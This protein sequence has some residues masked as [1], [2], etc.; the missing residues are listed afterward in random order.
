MRQTEPVGSST[1]IVNGSGG[2]GHLTTLVISPPGA[3]TVTGTTTGGISAAL[4]TLISTRINASLGAGTLKP[5]SGGGPLTANVLPVQG[6]MKV[7]ILFPGCGLFLPIPLTLGGTRGMG[8]GGPTFTVNTFSPGPLPR[9]T[10]LGAPWTIGVASI[11]TDFGTVVRRG[12]AH[13]PA[14]ATSST[15]RP[16]GVVQLVTP[17]VATT[18]LAPPGTRLP[19]FGVLRIHFVPEPGTALLLGGGLA[20]LGITGRKR[21]HG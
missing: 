15:A 16:S 10:L 18:S 14:S 3:I 2:G 19:I 17:V 7:C 12:F 9:F 6:S 11:S 21:R 20:L 13:G 5:I 1:A 4:P 8:I